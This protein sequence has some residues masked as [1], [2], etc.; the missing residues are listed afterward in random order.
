[1][2]MKMCLVGVLGAVL[3]V[4]VGCAENLVTRQHYDMIV[5]GKSTKLE[6]EK[7]LGDKYT[8]RGDDEWEYDEEDRHLAVYVYFDAGGK[9]EKKEWVDSKTGEWHCDPPDPTHG[10]KISDEAGTTT[11]KEE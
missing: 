11:I 7:T 8:A 1:M 10:R 6:V 3:F 4:A 2:Y 5:V 9:V